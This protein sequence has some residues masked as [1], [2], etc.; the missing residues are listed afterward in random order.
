MFA[1]AVWDS[2]LGELW[3]ARDRMGEKPLY[4]GDF[5]GVFAFASELKALRTIPECPA[6]VDSDAV[7]DVLERGYVRGART[8]LSGISKL[9][10]GHI[11]RVVGREAGF[12]TTATSYWSVARVLDH[13]PTPAAYDPTSAEDTLDGLLREVVRD[14][15]LADVP[16]GAFLSG[17]IDSSLI[18]ALMQQVS[19]ERVRTYTVGFDESKFDESAHARQIAA[20]LGTEHTAIQLDAADALRYVDLLPEIFDEPFA[21]SSQLPTYLVCQATRAHV[22]VALSGDGGD[23]LFGGYSQYLMPDRIAEWSQRFPRGVRSITAAGISAIPDA[24]VSALRPGST[25]SANAKSRMVGALQSVSPRQLHEQLLSEWA[26]ASLALSSRV[27]ASRRESMRDQ[28][29]W[30]A[31]PSSPEAAM[32]Y[33]MQTYLPD[34]ILVKVDRCAMAVSLETRA[35]LLDHRVVEFALR[36]PLAGKIREGTGKLILRR[37][38]GRYVP[39]SM[40]NRPKQ[41]FAMPLPDWLRTSLRPWAEDLMSNR[42]LVTEWFDGKRLRDL[43]AAHQRGEDHAE[44]LWRVLILLQWMQAGPGRA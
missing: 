43:W 33:D 14:E 30:P 19:S 27:T 3:L 37:L 25:W 31:A 24:V 13:V 41:G 36:L 42:A 35:P 6:R 4:F 15:T 8:I 34:D 28:L 26:N 23:E 2:Q 7:A 12:S 1:F 38:L 10:P 21:D 32:A 29:S 44:R 16:V 20:H 9:L 22:T 18:V 5:D 11:L 40:W 39:E 17:G